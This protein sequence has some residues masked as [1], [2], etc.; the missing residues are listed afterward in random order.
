MF[1]QTEN[2]VISSLPQKDDW[3]ICTC[4]SQMKYPIRSLTKPAVEPFCTYVH[5]YR[6]LSSVGLY[7]DANM[8]YDF[9]PNET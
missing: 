2:I 1:F 8:T 5:I 7:K 4:I 3:L 9:E 6:L